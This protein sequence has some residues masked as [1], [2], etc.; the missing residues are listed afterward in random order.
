L[1]FSNITQWK[2]TLSGLLLC[3]ITAAGVLSKGGVTIGNIGKGD[4]VVL[5]GALAT[6]FLGL[7][8]SDGKQS[9]PTTTNNSTTKLGAI[10]L[11]ALLIQLPFISGCS[12]TNVAQDIVKWTPELQSAVSMVDSTIA[13]LLPA[14]TALAVALTVGFDTGS[15]FVDALANS[16]LANPSATTLGKLQA[17]VVTFQQNVNSSMLGLLKLSTAA[18][19]KLLAAIQVVSTIINAI[20]ALVA[21]IS[22]KVSK[23]VMVSAATMKISQLES[24]RDYIWKL[25]EATLVSQH[26]SIPL[27]VAGTLAAQSRLSLSQQGF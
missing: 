9:L 6:A 19:Q 11:I 25:K 18:Q 27:N 8:A 12:A 7:L 23:A 4:I 2:T 26:Y 14:D 3:I 16:Y 15:N 13:T 1:N 21:S 5:I 24:Q 20:L 10:A 17:A 22:S